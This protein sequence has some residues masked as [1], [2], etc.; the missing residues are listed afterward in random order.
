MVRICECCSNINVENLKSVVPSDQ[1]EVACIGEC[2][3]YD[4]KSYGFIDDDLVVS[5]TELD[6]IEVVKSRLK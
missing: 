2:S 6:F 4:D 3:A 1:L 5:E